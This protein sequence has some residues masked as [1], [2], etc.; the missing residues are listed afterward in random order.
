MLNRTQP[1]AGKITNNK[2]CPLL[3]LPALS[4]II[5]ISLAWACWADSKSPDAAS[6]PSPSPISTPFSVLILLSWFS[7]GCK[8]LNRTH[9]RAGTMGSKRASPRLSPW[10]ISAICWA[11]KAG[12]TEPSVEKMAPAMAAPARVDGPELGLAILGVAWPLGR[13]KREMGF[14]GLGDSHSLAFFHL[15]FL[16]Y[17]FYIFLLTDEYFVFCLLDFHPKKIGHQTQIYHFKGLHHF[18]FELFNKLQVI[19]CYQKIIDI[20]RHDKKSLPL[21]FTYRVDSDTLLTKPRLSKCSSI[22]V[23]HALGACFRPYKAFLNQ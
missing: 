13:G 8:M 5:A 4:A 14:A 22:L 21:C 15:K 3:S 18:L 2:S 6:P 12:S 10:A 7:A 17:F 16:Q 23:Y 20:K 19:S 1:M 9:P 11:A